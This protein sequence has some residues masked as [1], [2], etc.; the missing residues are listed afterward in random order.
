MEFMASFI[1]G[2]ETDFS[3]IQIS[4]LTRQFIIS[5]NK[6]KQ[7]EIFNDFFD[8]LAD[9]NVTKLGLGLKQ[10]LRGICQYLKKSSFVVLLDS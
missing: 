6:C 5:I 7:S 4:T 9:N 10:D 1:P 8:L 2:E 3:L